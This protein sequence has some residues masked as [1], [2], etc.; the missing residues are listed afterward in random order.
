[1]IASVGLLAALTD[2]VVSR[3]QGEPFTFAG[4]RRDLVL[5]ALIDR[6]PIRTGDNWQSW[7]RRARRPL[8]FLASALLRLSIPGYRLKQFIVNGPSP[9]GTVPRCN[10]RVE[11]LPT[12]PP[13]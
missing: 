11:A 1:V 8:R 3:E 7:C 4:L 13:R 5:V 10:P 12:L 9:R 6:Y 2:L